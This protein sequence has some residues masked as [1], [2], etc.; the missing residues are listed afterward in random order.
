MIYN[1]HAF[2]HLF[3]SLALSAKIEIRQ[4]GLKFPPDLTDLHK[5]DKAN[6]FSTKHLSIF[7]K[8]SKL[9]GK[10]SLHDSSLI[11]LSFTIF[12]KNI[13]GSFSIKNSYFVSSSS[14]AMSAVP[15]KTRLVCCLPF[16]YRRQI[17]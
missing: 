1:A 2:P 3:C 10:I 9:S 16:S 7:L 15:S 13:W 11:K 12:R 14:D 6:D 8:P 17:D 4:I 5:Y